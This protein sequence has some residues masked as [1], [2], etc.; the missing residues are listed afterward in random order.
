[1]EF[2]ITIFISSGT[3]FLFAISPVPALTAV[4]TT[5]SL[6]GN[7]IGFISTLIGG[8]LSSVFLY[9]FVQ[10]VSDKII[11]KYF[12]S[13]IGRINRLTER[14]KKVSFI[15]L[16]LIM[17]SGQIPMKIISPACGIS[18][19]NFRKFI[20]ARA[21]SGIPINAVYIISTSNFNN[22]NNIFLR[23]N[24]SQ[25]KSLTFSIGICSIISYLIILIIKSM[26]KFKIDT[27]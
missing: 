16:L 17:M 4:I 24:S 21:I 10:K 3:I 9:F 20:I 19:I 2:L 13:N 6:K 15:E 1:M 25:I 14:I 27:D 8:L 5:Y 7:I 12:K 26:P 23:S 22:I 11:L 18:R